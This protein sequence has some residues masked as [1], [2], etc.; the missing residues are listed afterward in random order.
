MQHSIKY[1]ETGIHCLVHC[2]HFTVDSRN[3]RTDTCIQHS[4]RSPASSRLAAFTKRRDNTKRSQRLRCYRGDMNIRRR[5]GHEWTVGVAPSRGVNGATDILWIE[6]RLH[7][8]A[9]LTRSGLPARARSPS[10]VPVPAPAEVTRRPNMA[11]RA[12]EV[13]SLP[14]GTSPSAADAAANP[15]HEPACLDIDIRKSARDHHLAN[16]LLTLLSKNIR[17]R[18]R[19]EPEPEPTRSCTRE[20]LPRRGET[21]EGRPRRQRL[22]FRRTRTHPSVPVGARRRRAESER[23][24]RSSLSQLRLVNTNRPRR[25]V[26]KIFDLHSTHTSARADRVATRRGEPHT[27]A[28][29]RIARAAAVAD[30][31][32]CQFFQKPDMHRHCKTRPVPRGSAASLQR[33]LMRAHTPHSNFTQQLWYQSRKDL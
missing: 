24:H 11:A 33:T 18:R 16:K 21:D 17:V 14:I 27:R 8:A 25:R 29:L 1:E 22:G 32:L 10:P 12:Q 31:L 15:R 20:P 28:R 6:S 5:K 23:D 2:S 3:C 4:A 9:P 7:W 30:V 26:G 13:R 19:A